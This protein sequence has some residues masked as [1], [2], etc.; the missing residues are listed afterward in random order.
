MEIPEKIKPR[1]E[2]L[3]E[4]FPPCSHSNI[5]NSRYDYTSIDGTK[6]LSAKSS[7]SKTVIDSFQLG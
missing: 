6:H 1:L 7:K 5:R 2:K 4:L 3:K